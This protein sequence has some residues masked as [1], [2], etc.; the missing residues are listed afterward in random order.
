MGAL[1]PE[2]LLKRAE[3]AEARRA[4]FA[5]LMRDCYRYAM[6]ERD[7]WSS[8]A[9]GQEKTAPD[10]YD[11]TAIVAVSRFANRFQQAMFPAQQRWCRAALPPELAADDAA[12]EVQEGLDAFTET[13]FR[14]IHA[15]NFDATIPE[16]AHDLAAGTACLLIE[17]G[18]LGTNRR[19]APRLRFQALPAA[20]VAFDEGP[21][22]GVEGVFLDQTLPARLVART[23]PDADI[24]AELRRKADTEPEADVRLLQATT[25][26]PEDDMF[27]FQVLHRDS[28][29]ELLRRRYRTMP[30]VIVR[31]L[32][33]PGEHYG[34]GPLTQV[35]PS[36]RVVNKLVE[37]RLKALS[38]DVAGIWTVVDDGVVNLDNFRIVPGAAIPVRSNG[39]PLGP[40]L[41]RVESGANYQYAEAELQRL[42]TTIRQVLFDDPLPPEVTAGLTAT[43]VIERVR[44]FQADTGA[45]GRLQQ[46]AVAPIFVR[47]VDILEDA[48]EL[49]DPRFRGWLERL[50]DQAVRVQPTSPLSQAQD[51]AD[52][53][54]V[55]MTVQ[56]LAS[57]GEPGGIMLK[58]AVNLPAAG[59]YVAE[60]NGVPHQLIPT[61]Q[62]LAAA[63]QAQATAA[64]DQALLTSPAVAQVAGAVAKAAVTPAGAPAA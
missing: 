50:Q 25:Y 56:G 51:R 22:G 27:H 61:E 38:L 5:S 23:Y 8:Y 59:R 30:W 36:I 20:L 45:F 41:R 17:D 64:Q 9:P 46:D 37:L 55:M 52:V 53:Q 1:P 54:A 58:A 44:R 6:P 43:E 48:G 34:R 31:W 10:C 63:N 19:R 47:C 33:A 26:D 11:D 15:S 2:Q 18:R 40:S 57:I 35:L 13:V 4:P 14:H 49:R 32:K 29:E 28:K 21:F 24:P 60:R 16:V 3:R 42:V 7:A 12:Q 39:G 62:D